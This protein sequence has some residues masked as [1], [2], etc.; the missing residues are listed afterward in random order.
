MQGEGRAAATGESPNMLRSCTLAF[1]MLLLA[2]PTLASAQTTATSG[3]DPASCA[4]PTGASGTTP[5]VTSSDGSSP[6]GTELAGDQSSASCSD[7][8]DTSSAGGD[9]SM[10][11]D[12]PL[13]TVAQ[14]PEPDPKGP[15]EEQPGERGGEPQPPTGEEAPATG[16]GLLQTGLEALKLVLLGLVLVLVG[17]RIRAV[18][19]RRRSPT[20]LAPDGLPYGSPDV[21][22][23]PPTSQAR[24]SRKL[25]TRMRTREYAHAGAEVRRAGR[26]EWPFPDP[27]EPA[28]TGLL[29]STVTARRKARRREDERLS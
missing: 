19:R 21:S 7:P 18:V 20:Q 1:A 5:A 6:D 16:G 9:A 12:V 4:E 27:D 22:E 28:P 23:L 24:R 15:G 13:S 2:L 29:P 26:D 25:S 17:A 14:E 10:S 3:T 11:G 8:A